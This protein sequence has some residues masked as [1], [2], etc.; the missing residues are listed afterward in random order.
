GDQGQRMLQVDA[1]RQL[2]ASDSG[3]AVFENNATGNGRFVTA[4]GAANT[5]SGIISAGSVSDLTQV[6]GHTYDLAFAVDA[7]TG[8]TTYTVTET[9]PGTTGTAQPY[10]SGEAITI[11]GMQFD[12]K[13]SPAN[14]DT[15]NLKP[16]SNQSIF[17]TLNNLLNTL[18]T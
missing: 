3:S 17:T 4:A 12:I 8:A 16:S 5:G 13:G 9:P 10:A 11:G 15:F 2:A 1:S 18:T 7:T 6:N 14:G